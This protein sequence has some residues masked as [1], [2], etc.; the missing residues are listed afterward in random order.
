MEPDQTAP[1]RGFQ[2]ITYDKIDKFQVANDRESVKMHHWWAINFISVWTII[3]E[4]LY[5][6][7]LQ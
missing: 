7:R 1:Y 6:N 2:N 3:G 4:V 5:P